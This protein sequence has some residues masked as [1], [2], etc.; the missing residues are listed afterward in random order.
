M[1]I[2]KTYYVLIQ[3]LAPYLQS[4]L[5]RVQLVKNKNK[6]RIYALLIST[7]P[8]NGNSHAHGAAEQRIADATRKAHGGRIEEKCNN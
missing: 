8:V 7:N 2:C 6:W 5:K 3:A 1:S 4:F